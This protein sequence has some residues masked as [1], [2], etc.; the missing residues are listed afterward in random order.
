M[1]HVKSI[2]IKGYRGFRT[3]DLVVFAVPDGSYASGLTLLTGPNNSGKTSILEVVRALGSR[4]QPSFGRSQRNSLRRV[5]R[6]GDPDAIA[7]RIGG[8]TGCT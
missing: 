8:I 1:K 2:S 4:R 6:F 5:L 7:A 3:E